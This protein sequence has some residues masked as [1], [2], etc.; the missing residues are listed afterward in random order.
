MNGGVKH[1][2]MDEMGRGPVIIVKTGRGRATCITHPREPITL[3][4]ADRGSKATTDSAASCASTVANRDKAD[5]EARQSRKPSEFAS[6]RASSPPARHEQETRLW[7][8][9]P[10]FRL[11]DT[12]RKSLSLRASR[13][14]HVGVHG[15]A[16]FPLRIV[17][18]HGEG[19]G[20]RAEGWTEVRGWVCGCGG[21]ERGVEDRRWMITRQSW[22]CI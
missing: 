14:V 8:C 21:D 1:G 2:G 11:E 3:G 5:A 16:S 22:S 6:L 9:W 18:I 13:R 7:W 12:H 4:G 15:G 17:A 10:A 19:G 20:R